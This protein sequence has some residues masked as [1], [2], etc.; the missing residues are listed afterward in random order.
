MFDVLVKEVKRLSG[1]ELTYS[2]EK[3]EP[4]FHSLHE[5]Y[6]VLAEEVDEAR[7]DAQ[8]VREQFCGLLELIRDDNKDRIRSNLVSLNEYAIEAAAE[9]IQVSAMAQKM[10][11]IVKEDK[12]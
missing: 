6:G 11:E 1:Y 8:F 9:Y 10:L 4:Q 12:T 5:G 2:R 7:I 3:H